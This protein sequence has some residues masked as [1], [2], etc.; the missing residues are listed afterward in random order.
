MPWRCAAGV[1]LS[2]CKETK[3]P[4]PSD[5]ITL[6]Q[7]VERPWLGADFWANRLQDWQLNNGRIE[8]PRGEMS[9]EGRTYH[10]HPYSRA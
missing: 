1:G 7:N 5:K 2:A 10:S 8:C 6:D 9:F 3:L 4:A